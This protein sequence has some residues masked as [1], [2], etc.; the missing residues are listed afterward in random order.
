VEKRIA[1][2]CTQI[3]KY[4]SNGMKIPIDKTKTMAFKGSKIIIIN[5][6]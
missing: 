1:T 3:R 4:Q 5:K 2:V 6:I